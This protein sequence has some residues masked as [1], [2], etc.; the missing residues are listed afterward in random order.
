LVDVQNDLLDNLQTRLDIPLYPP[1]SN[2]TLIRILNP[3]VELAT[4]IFFLSTS[5]MT[6][7]RDRELKQMIGSLHHMRN[8]I[9]AAV[10]L[11]FTGI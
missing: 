10:D 8:E 6:A 11:L 5:E 7:V 9:I 4:G 2:S 1:S 3:T